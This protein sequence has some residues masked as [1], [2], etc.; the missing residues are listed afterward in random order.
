MSR[1]R[2][3]KGKKVVQGRKRLH[4]ESKKQ[5]AMMYIDDK[6]SEDS[7]DEDGGV[8]KREDAYYNP[9]QLKRKNAPLNL[10]EVADK[11][12][13]EGQDDEEEDDDGDDDVELPAGYADDDIVNRSL[14]P[15]P[16]KDP[17]LW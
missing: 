8:G 6:A 9:D 11:Y 5:A 12:A 10:D 17:K 15:S 2:G 3:K 7:D 1:A 13:I 4:K 14:L 16:N